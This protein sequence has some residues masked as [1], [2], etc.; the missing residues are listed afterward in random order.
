V[1]VRVGQ[2]EEA[3]APGGVARRRVWLDAMF[4]SK[5][6]KGVN[7]RHMEDD[8]APECPGHLL[9]LGDEV[10]VTGA[11]AETCEGRGLT[12]VLQVEAE[13]GVELHRPRHIQGCQ[14]DRTDAL[15][16]WDDASSGCRYGETLS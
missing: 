1:A 5:C 10:E 2:V 16:H 4:N 3:F 11:G 12:A 7:V 8:P 13:H 6:T 9:G 15:D 14:G